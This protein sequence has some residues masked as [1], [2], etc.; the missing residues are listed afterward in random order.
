MIPPTMRNAWQPERER[1][2]AR[3]ELREAVVRERRDLEAA[4]AEEQ[5]DEQEPGGAREPGLVGP[6]RVDAVG[7][8]GG[9]DRLAVV[10]HLEASSQ[11]G[12]EDASVGD[13]LDRLD[14]L[15]AG[16]VRV[17]PGVDPHLKPLLHVADGVVDRPR[18]GGE[19]AEAEHRVEVPPGGD[20]DHREVDPE[21]QERRAEV[22]HHGQHAKRD[23]GHEHQRAEVARRREADTEDRAVR[24]RQH[25][26]VLA[27]EARQEDD[28]QQLRELAGLH[29]HA[30]EAQPQLRAVHRCPHHHGHEQEAD[31]RRSEQVSVRLQPA[32]VADEKH[33]PQ[34]PQEADDDPH[35]LVAG[36]RG[37][38]AVDL[39]EAERAQERG[40]RQEPRV[41]P[42]QAGAHAD[43]RQAEDAEEHPGVGQRGARD[44]V[45]T[46]R[47][48]R[49]EA[50]CRERSDPAEVPELAHPFR[51]H[52]LA[53][54]YGRRTRCAL[55]SERRVWSKSR[56]RWSGA[57]DT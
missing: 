20:V 4:V 40:Q 19:E 11:S 38:E 39:G 8:D 27:Q 34:E 14:D 48:D 28:Q 9:D 46:G 15:V 7:L 50:D 51:P 26:A 41:G 47:V 6:G 13:R 33:H 30:L 57:S 12:P 29:L 25:L 45:L 5:V 22:V 35:G 3:E 56:R 43:M 2:A 24:H 55:D 18:A 52:G 36:Q 53:T 49:Q 37:A 1:E 42:R 44:L 54:S 16:R 10:Q 17:G 23:A 31:R 21:E 32:V